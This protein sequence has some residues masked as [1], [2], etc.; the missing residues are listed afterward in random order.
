MSRRHLLRLVA[1]APGCLAFGLGPAVAHASPAANNP[2]AGRA[3]R[4]WLAGRQREITAA[5]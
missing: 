5:V 2:F 4:S 1:L 3:L